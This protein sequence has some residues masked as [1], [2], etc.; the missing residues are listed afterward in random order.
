MRQPNP[1]ATPASEM[2][3]PAP[4]PGSAE[5]ILRPL[6]H[7]LLIAAAFVGLALV[8]M[9]VFHARGIHN[10]PYRSPRLA[11]LKVQLLSEPKNEALKQEIR[12]LDLLLRQRHARDV[13]VNRFGTWFLVVSTVLLV[14]GAKYSARLRATVPAPQGSADALERAAATAGR[15]RRVAITT[16]AVTLGAL[17]LVSLSAR[18]SLPTNPSDVDRFLARLHGETTD[19]PAALPSAAE[20]ASNWPRFLGPTPNPFVSNA[21]LPLAFELASG[22][23]ILWKTPV[24]VAGFN[25]PIIWSNRV[26][27]SGGDA[28]TR[29]VL[30]FDLNS[31]AQLWQRAVANVPG[32]PAKPPDIPESTGFAAP[33]MATDGLRVYAI[34]AN[35]DLAAFTL[36]GRPAWS[37]SLGVPDNPYGHAISLAVFEGNLIVQL[38]QGAEDDNKSK[39]LA[40]DGATGSVVWQTPRPVGASWAS[41]A[42]TEAA[43]KPQVI[44][45]AGHLIIAYHAR[46]G[47]ELW[48]AD[49]IGGEITPSP[50]FAGGYFLIASPSDTLY[51]I[52]PDGSGDVTKTHVAWKTEENIP[53]VTSPVSNGALVFTALSH[54]IVTCHDLADGQKLWEHEMDTEVHATPAIV[55]DRLCVFGGHGLVLVMAA[56]REAKE[57]AKFELG[58][59]VFASPAFAHGRMVVRTA[60]TLFAVS[61]AP[62]PPPVLEASRP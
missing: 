28:Q 47:A 26:F 4:V 13:A 3:A 40:F 37:K 6:H 53:D 36:D 9:L 14:V 57:L 43:G 45:L 16:G 30:C 27:L 1:N 58:E 2:T 31:G 50:I 24:P 35:G 21:T 59:A 10:D 42:V 19:E 39:L 20:F 33:T 29:S 15:A 34:F 56:A 46:D 12:D 49:L 51:A 32:S 18:S 25:S 8:V 11:A 61:T 5:G 38:D 55:G 17:L 60:A 44:T 48:R 62:T 22:N 54:G 7:T 41:P 52:R 23:G